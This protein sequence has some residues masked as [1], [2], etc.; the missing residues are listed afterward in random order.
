MYVVPIYAC[1]ILYFIGSV[2]WTERTTSIPLWYAIKAYKSK[3]NF[4]L[5]ETDV[6]LI[7]HESL[8]SSIMLGVSVILIMAGMWRV[9]IL[10]LKT[11]LNPT[12]GV[13]YQYQGFDNLKKLD[14]RCTAR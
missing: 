6:K 4:G 2:D 7:V 1:Q 9:Q 10:M 3:Y 11:D 5:H 13:V 8:G 12:G 14:R